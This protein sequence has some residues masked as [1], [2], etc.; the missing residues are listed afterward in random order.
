MMPKMP[1]FGVFTQSDDANDGWRAAMEQAP[2]DVALPASFSR[3]E[4]EHVVQAQ[5]LTTLDAYLVAPRLGRGTRLSREMKRRVWAVFQEYRAE[6]NQHRRKEYVDLLRAA[7]QLLEQKGLKRP[8]RAVI[9]DEA[10]DLRPR[11]S[12]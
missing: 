11:P 9:V 10:Q 5:N 2:A 1:K 12:G 3:V 4:W 6:L 8:Y 7:R